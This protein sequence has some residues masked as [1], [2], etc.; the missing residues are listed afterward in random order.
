MA[1]SKGCGR[2]CPWLNIGSSSCYQ[3]LSSEH[4]AQACRHSML[5]G[6]VN[7][8]RSDW[9]AGVLHASWVT[10][11]LGAATAMR[12]DTCLLF[13]MHHRWRLQVK[14]M[15]SGVHLA[16]CY[17]QHT[18]RWG[19]TIPTTL[20]VLY[21]PSDSSPSTHLKVS[22]SSGSPAPGSTMHGMPQIPTPA[23]VATLDALGVPFDI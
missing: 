4:A 23:P 15:M 1:A 2:C 19:C 9:S 11:S 8:S 20:M 17:I 12:T 6:M 18:S 3:H 13:V 10:P 14:A 5:V 22:S 16:L 7:R 21:T